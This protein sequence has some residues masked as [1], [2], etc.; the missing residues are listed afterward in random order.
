MLNG[1]ETT[2]MFGQQ[3][4]GSQFFSPQMFQHMQGAS[5]P[6]AWTAWS[7]GVGQMN[8]EMM[9]YTKSAIEDGTATYRE[10]L[11]ARSLEEAFDIQTR[12]ARRSAEEFAEQAQK[13]GNLYVRLLQQAF[14][15]PQ[16]GGPFRTSP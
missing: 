16:A 3:L 6:P 5:W 9:A 11:A 10:L 1:F 15:L 8:R 4:F 12:Y 2:P 14:Q 13:M 7:Q